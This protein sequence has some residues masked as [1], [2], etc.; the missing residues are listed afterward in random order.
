MKKD[1]TN[2]TSRYVTAPGLTREGAWSNHNDVT[3]SAD[4]LCVAHLLYNTGRHCLNSSSPRLQGL[5][6]STRAHRAAPPS[7]RSL[8]Q[9]RPSV[10][11]TETTRLTRFLPKFWGSQE[12]SGTSASR[13]TASLGSLS[14]TSG[15]DRQRPACCLYTVRRSQL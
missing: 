14:A 11:M 8:Q 10:Q 6:S 1:S 4:I 15:R 12:S 3:D 13:S 9:Q 2:P 7:S 5:A